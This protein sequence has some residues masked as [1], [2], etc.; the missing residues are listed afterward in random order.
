MRN[1]TIKAINIFQNYKLPW[2]VFVLKNP[3][4]EVNTWLKKKK[5][6]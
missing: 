1:Y 3:K 5:K 6:G 2:Q 4:Q